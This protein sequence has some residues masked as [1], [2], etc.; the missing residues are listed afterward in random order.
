MSKTTNLRINPMFA[1]RDL[2]KI[3]TTTL[4]WLLLD[5]LQGAHQIVEEEFARSFGSLYY[6]S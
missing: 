1:E 5:Y 4:G 3:V 6:P 2:S